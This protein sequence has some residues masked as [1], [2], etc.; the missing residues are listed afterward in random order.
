VRR[1]ARF[2]GFFQKGY[3]VPPIRFS[4]L[5][6]V[7]VLIGLLVTLTACDL[8]F[9]PTATPT[10]PPVPATAPPPETTVAQAPPAT[11]TTA[12]QAPPTSVP[13]TALPP[14]APTAPSSE[15]TAAP[16]AQ[17]TPTALPGRTVTRPA[18]SPTG[19]TAATA[20]PEAAA[21]NPADRTESL[22]NTTLIPGR[23][24]YDLTRRLRLKTTEPLTATVRAT[25]LNRKVGDED[26]FNVADILNKSYYTVTATVK[27]VTTHAYWYVDNAYDVN[28]NAVRKSAKIWEDKIYPT[29]RKYFGSERSPGIDGDVHIT[30]LLSDIA[31]VGGYFSSSDSYSK[32]VNP[33]SNEREMIYI[34]SPPETTVGSGNYFEGVLA[35]EFQHM[36]HASVSPNRDVW[37]DEGCSDVAMSLNNYDVGGADYAYLLDPDTQLNA[38]AATPDESIAHYGASYLF[39]RYMMQRFGG[40]DFVKA[41]LA[42]PGSGV[43]AFDGALQKLGA[44]QNFQS[45]FT[46]WLVANMVNDPKVGDG[47]YAYDALKS[48]YG[49]RA[50]IDDDAITHV[51]RYPYTVSADVHQHAGDYI[52]LDSG[53][54]DTVVNF[55][56]SRAVKVLDTDAHSGQTF[57]YSN[58][59]DAANMTLTR[60]FDLTGLSKATLDYWTWFDIEGDFDYG[61]AEVSTDDGQSW[62]TLKGQYTTDTNPNGANYGHGYTG[63]SGH[64]PKSDA[65]PL[66]VHEQLDLSRYAGKPIQVRFDYVTDEGFNEPGWAIDDISIPELNYHSD[67]ESDDG[68]WQAA[69]FVRIANVLPQHWYVAAIEYKKGGGVTVVPL[70]V[71]ADGQ[72]QL[73]IAGLG[74]TLSKAVL[75]VSGLAP[76]TTETASYLLAVKKR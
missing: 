24:L 59:R 49:A 4:L 38:W 1:P 37:L 67:A 21:A 22:L 29:D 14:T 71:D 11:A 5:P 10:A 28:M 3:P 17:R 46:D 32:V 58:R 63:P 53:Q 47:R 69:G 27:V 65:A 64:D 33:Y 45:A 9:G 40:A 76:T 19:A 54:G 39:L 51:S 35:H 41:L 62:D 57:W 66:W 72:G 16:P 18:A 42:S 15:D 25:P 7:G 56:G 44:K 48:L 23:D 70:P 52:S 13:P 74:K 12:T 20:T 73:T 60:S 50:R 61:Y 43:E 55:N 68:G 6:R 30:I 31:G 34:A 36:I 2:T 75:V 8:G 26:V